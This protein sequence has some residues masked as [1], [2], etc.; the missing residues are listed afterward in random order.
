MHC[1]HRYFD[2]AFDVP[3]PVFDGGVWWV[4]SPGRDRRRLGPFQSKKRADDIRNTWF[5]KWADRARNL[6]GWVWKRTEE[7]WVVT[8]PHS[9]IPTGRPLDQQVCSRHT[10]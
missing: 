6:E 10:N 4:C 1:G 9:A 8:T 7:V 3:L 2:R 5:E